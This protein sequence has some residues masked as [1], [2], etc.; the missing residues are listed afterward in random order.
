M[1][2]I[3]NP[4]PLASIQ[5]L[6]RVGYRSIGVGCAGVMDAQS[7]RIVNL[8]LGNDENAAVVE[9]TYGDFELVA[10]EDVTV[11]V[12]GADAPRYVDD[13]PI[14]RW[15]TQT[16]KKGQRLRCAFCET[17]MRVYLAFVGGINVPEVMGSRSTDVKAGFG[18]L[19]GRMLQA[20]DRLKPVSRCPA[21]SFSPFALDCTTFPEL[22]ER[23]GDAPV[24]RFIPA[25]EWDD[26]N[27]VNQALFVESE[28][29]LSFESNRVGARLEGP[30]LEP[31]VRRELLSHGILPG[32][33]QLPPSGLP[34]IQMREANTCGGY[35]KIGTV[36]DVDFARVAQVPLGDNIRFQACTLEEAR[37]ARRTADERLKVLAR[38]C[39][40][41]RGEP[42]S[43][44]E[45]SGS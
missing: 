6:G 13:E 39:K 22:F 32:T 31:T 44:Y 10:C 35:P 5:D 15:W 17:G 25:A 36:I 16:L 19:D 21:F 12:G 8:M 43:Q 23:R 40:Q 42:A 30:V 37:A 28:W 14:P 1:I 26:L 24:L 9:C 33:I 45:A 11:A 3:L 41:A 38:F 4:G 27:E 20:G 2:E 29:T 34:L 18:G 7:A